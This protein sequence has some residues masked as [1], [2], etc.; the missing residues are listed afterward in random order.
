MSRLFLSLPT[1]SYR[2]FLLDKPDLISIFQMFSF[3]LSF[4]PVYQVQMK[5]SAVYNSLDH[6]L[7]GVTG[8]HF[9]S[10]YPSSRHSSS[11]VG[12]GRKRCTFGGRKRRQQDSRADA[13][14]E[15]AVNAH[16]GRHRQTSETMQI[17]NLLERLR[18]GSV[19]FR[20]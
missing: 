7:S 15:C 5:G 16:S 10:F 20:R 2:T 1:T 13:H 19:S 11:P 8:R 12:R 4:Q 14:A 3:F 9:C 18:D 17:P 6:F